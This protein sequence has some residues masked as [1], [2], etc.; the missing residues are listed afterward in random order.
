MNLELPFTKQQIEAIAAKYPTPFHIY[1]EA[2][3]MANDKVLTEAFRAAG[4]IDFKNYFAVKALPNPHI[5]KLL[6]ASGQGLDCS[7][8]A[9]LELADKIGVSGENIMFT[10]NNT[11][12]KEYERANNLGA[13]INFDD[14][15]H[16]QPFI[17]SFGAPKVVCCRYNPGNL[18]FSASEVIMGAPAEAKYGMTKPQVIEAYK[19]LKNAGVK[20]FGMHAML[21]SND[22]DYRNHVKIAKSLFKLA[23]DVG[24]GLE[25]INLGGGIGVPYRSHEKPFDL[26]DFASGV[27]KVYDKAGLNNPKIVMENGRF[28]SADAGYLVTKVINIK[29]TYKKFIGVDASM[30]NLMRPGMYGAYHHISV[31]GRENEP[32]S[33]TVDVTGSLCENNDKF[34]VNRQL[35]AVAVGD[36]LVI[37]TTGAHGHAMG[38]QYN[39]KLR[40]AELLL[41]PSGKVICI[42][43]AET[44]DDYFATLNGKGVKSWL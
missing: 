42:R 24:V 7:S 40:S 41:N 26:S 9:E 34:A 17:D 31:L 20:R 13:V 6:T 28:I 1:D 22:L 37:H 15:S 11:A 25:F 16:V 30:P 12:A 10:S 19:L 18:G 27:R 39:G 8:L 44:L 23:A 3:I 2:R 38:F 36:Y 5:L 35:P 33:E 21:L 14:V 4:F 29:N 43:R 32:A